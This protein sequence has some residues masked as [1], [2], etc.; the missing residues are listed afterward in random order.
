MSFSP[1]YRQ[2]YHAAVAAWLAPM[3]SWCYPVYNGMCLLSILK[4]ARDILSPSQQHAPSS[5]QLSTK[6]S[7]KELN[8]PL[9]YTSAKWQQQQ[10]CRRSIQTIFKKAFQIWSAHSFTTN[11]S[12]F[13]HHHGWAQH[14]CDGLFCLMLNPRKLACQSGLS[15]QGLGDIAVSTSIGS[16]TIYLSS[17]CDHTVHRSCH[18]R[19]KQRRL[20]VLATLKDASDM[21]HRRP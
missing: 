16:Q 12:K 18:L 10:H 1:L 9:W 11:D 8:S 17:A 20:L 15:A 5:A 7:S 13:L 6:T 3:T 14:L 4:C 21:C 2:L 19:E